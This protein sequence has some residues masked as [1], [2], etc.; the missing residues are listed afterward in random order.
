MVYMVGADCYELNSGCY[1]AYGF[2][3]KPG[4]DDNA[5]CTFPPSSKLGNRGLIGYDSSRV[6]HHVDQ[7]EQECVD[8]GRWGYSC[9]YQGE[10]WT[11]VGSTGTGGVFRLAF[12]RADR[13]MDLLPD[14]VL[15]VFPF[16]SI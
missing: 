9:R 4:F 11:K 1:A 5:V 10:Y 7:Q 3:Y 12:Y 15:Y 14:P 8:D 6:V 16:S 2:E 13:H